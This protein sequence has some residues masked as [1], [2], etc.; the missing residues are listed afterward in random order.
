MVTIALISWTTPECWRHQSDCST[1][2]A[3]PQART[4]LDT[5]IWFTEAIDDAIVAVTREMGY[6]KL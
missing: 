2:R 3:P 6:S 1:P 5:R 4:R